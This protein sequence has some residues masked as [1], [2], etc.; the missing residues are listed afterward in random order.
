ML[1]Q[2]ITTAAKNID[3]SVDKSFYGKLDSYVATHFIDKND[4]ERAIIQCYLSDAGLRIAKA[5]GKKKLEAEDAKAAI[6][7]YHLPVSADDPCIAAGELV[8]EKE[9]ERKQGGEEL[10]TA[11]FRKFIQ[12]VE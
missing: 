2:T 8:L 4:R 1:I 11:D 7:F 9:V 5:E 3:L 6:Y 10:L 12:D